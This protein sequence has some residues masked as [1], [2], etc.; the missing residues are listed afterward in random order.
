VETLAQVC[1]SGA[2][3][4]R[5]IVDVNMV[6]NKSDDQAPERCKGVSVVR[7]GVPSSTTTQK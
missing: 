1:R 6:E 7:Y 5:S 2:L 4:L 3:A